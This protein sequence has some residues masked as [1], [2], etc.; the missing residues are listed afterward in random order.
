MMD[1][2]PN[3]PRIEAGARVRSD[4]ESGYKSYGGV[5]R[6][7]HALRYSFDGLRE[8]VRVEAA[9]RQEL[10]LA[11]ILTPLAWWL[12]V[13]TMERVMLIGVLFIVLIVELLNS[14]L[15]AVVDRISLANHDLSRRAKDFGSAAVFVAL[16]LTALVW[17]AIGLPA[18]LRAF[19]C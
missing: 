9:F 10:L 17:L 5:Q 16:A 7:F 1:S 2:S 6:L 15:E 8:A 13:T 4:G 12:P 19:H 3:Q 18:A 11:A 14:G